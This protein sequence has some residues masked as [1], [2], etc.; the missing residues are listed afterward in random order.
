[1][2][3]KETKRCCLHAFVDK[4][5]SRETRAF[6]RLHHTQTPS[7]KHDTSRPTQYTQDTHDN[8]QPQIHASK[9][10]SVRAQIIK[11]QTRITTAA[12]TN[13]S[14]DIQ[15]QA[16]IHQQ[17]TSSKTLRGGGAGGQ[18]NTH[19]SGSISRTEDMH[20]T[21]RRAHPPGHQRGNFRSLKSISNNEDTE[22]TAR[23]VN[24]TADATKQNGT[25]IT[26][27]IVGKRWE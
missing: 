16:N 9:I 11:T 26:F 12:G 13:G 17:P 19:Y 23:Q 22:Y 25:R 20:T 7:D 27:F 21:A 15:H 5:R 8:T 6:R 4:R 10:C 3:G 14:R 1:M 18:G 2:R 24:K